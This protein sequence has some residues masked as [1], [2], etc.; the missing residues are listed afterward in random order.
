MANQGVALDPGNVRY[1]NEAWIGSQHPAYFELAY[2][3]GKFD[4][5]FHMNNLWPRE[6]FDENV[7][8][9]LKTKAKNGN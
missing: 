4:H 6:R 7:N 5:D 8:P 1:E 3:P 2:S 9:L